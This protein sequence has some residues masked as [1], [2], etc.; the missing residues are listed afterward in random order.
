M[1]KI[2]LFILGLFM[3][4]GSFGQGHLPITGLCLSDVLAYL[5]CEACVPIYCLADCFTRADPTYFDPAYAVSGNCLD[6][7]RNYGPQTCTRPGGMTQWEGYSTIWNGFFYVSFTT[8]LS[9][10]CAALVDHVQNGTPIH[11]FTGNSFGFESSCSTMAD[12][13]VWYN[14]WNLTT[15]NKVPNGYYLI[16]HA[17]VNDP[18]YYINDGVLTIY[19]CAQ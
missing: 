6:D 11:G 17:T 1:K 5:D 2:K 12:N 8:S 18:I 16:E 3:S 4:I 9:S 13:C 15:C 19:S 14:G 10:A 7:F